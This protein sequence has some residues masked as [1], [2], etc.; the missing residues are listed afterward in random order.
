ME[1]AMEGRLKSPLL[2]SVIAIVMLM[3]VGVGLFVVFTASVAGTAT[4]PNGTTAKINGA[5]SCSSDPTKTLISAGGR[6]F[7]FSTTTISIDGV[8]IGPLDAT[9]T[10]VQINSSFWSASLKINGTEV[11]R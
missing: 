4:L 3:V 1:N 8:P 5:F 6:Q 7:L 2:L 11:V 9:I 10:D